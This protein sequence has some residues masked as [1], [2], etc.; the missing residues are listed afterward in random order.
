MRLTQAVAPLLVLGL[1]ACTPSHTG[2]PAGHHQ[3]GAT[4][5]GAPTGAALLNVAGK[6]VQLAIQRCVH[7]GPDGVNVTAADARTKASLVVNL[8]RPVGAS[9]LVYTTRAKDNSFTNYAV[10]ATQVHAAITGSVTGSRVS[11][12]GTAARQSYR[13]DGKQDGHVIAEAVRLDA[14]CPTIQ[15]PQAAPTYARRPAHPHHRK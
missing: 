9:T 12:S 14:T 2:S 10:A 5:G 11:L 13:A 6:T 4:G 3:P 1:A 15:A 8:M 7:S